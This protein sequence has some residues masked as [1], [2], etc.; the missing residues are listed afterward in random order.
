MAI[1]I[2]GL[3]KKVRARS[4]EV[5]GKFVMRRVRR[6]KYIYVKSN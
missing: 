5:N 6:K 4:V 3:N 2:K 1:F